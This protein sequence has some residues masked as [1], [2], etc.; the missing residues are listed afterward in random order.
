[1]KQNYTQII[2]IYTRKK[3]VIYLDPCIHNIMLRKNSPHKDCIGE[4]SARIL[5]MQKL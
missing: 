3:L 2:S 4:N 1:M 5:Q